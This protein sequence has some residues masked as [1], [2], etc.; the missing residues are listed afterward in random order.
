MRVTIKIDTQSDF[1]IVFL[2]PDTLIVKECAFVIQKSTPQ[3]KQ[4]ICH[5]LFPQKRL[6]MTS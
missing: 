6:Y 3:Y 1:N 5:Y 4:V 2:V